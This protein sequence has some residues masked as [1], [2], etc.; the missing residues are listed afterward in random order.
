MNETKVVK[1]MKE[2]SKRRVIVSWSGGKDSCLAL[3]RLQQQHEVVCLLSMVS[4]KDG[5]SHTHGIRLP[6]LTLQA[7]ALGLPLV[8]VDSAGTYEQ[9]FQH[10][11]VETKE[12]YGAD[13]VAFGSLYEEED[14]HW[15]ESISYKAGLKALFP[16]WTSKEESSRLLEEFILLGFRS[17][18]CRASQDYFDKTW[19]GR[20]LGWRFFY[21]M[22]QTGKAVMGELGEYHSFVLDGPNFSKKLDITKAETVLNQGLWSLDIQD[23]QLVAKAGAVQNGL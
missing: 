8:L 9:S 10:A 23:C 1:K 22:E 17:V 16:L 12:K 5:R 7:K 11:L 6:I 15:N 19:V 14:R 4:K 13:A 20:M 18:I 21:D 2:K 3:Y